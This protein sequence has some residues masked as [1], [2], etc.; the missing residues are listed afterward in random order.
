MP[1]LHPEAREF[2]DLREDVGVLPYTSVT[3]DAARE[4]ATEQMRTD[5]PLREVANVRDTE[6]PGPNG[7]V[8][9]R[10]YEP[11]ASAPVPVVVFYHGGGW[12]INDLDTHDAMCRLL[13]AAGE[14]LVVASDYRR[15]PEHRFPAPVEDCYAVA[16]WTEEYA[17]KLG[18][19]TERVAVVG[20]S[21]GGNL[22]AATALLACDRDDFDLSHQVLLYPV[23]DFTFD[24]DSYEEHATGYPATRKDLEAFWEHYLPSDIQGANPYASPLRASDLSE[25]ASATVV[26]VEFD[27]LRDEGAAYA[28]RLDNAGSLAVHRKVD[29]MFHGYLQLVQFLPR[30]REDVAELAGRLRDRI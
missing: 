22:A 19:D 30:A 16:K 3:P 11:E 27:P 14:L 7:G 17:G 24:T 18:G 23:T 25:V 21:A 4:M 10:I 12:V 13:A 28:E 8:P 2:L 26:T 20:D 9:I 5:A 15:A 29:D 1:E 6:V